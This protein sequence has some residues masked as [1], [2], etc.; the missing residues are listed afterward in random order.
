MIQD[1]KHRAAEAARITDGWQPEWMQD[2]QYKNEPLF[3]V[4]A[5]LNDEAEVEYYETVTLADYINDNYEI[6]SWGGSTSVPLYCDTVRF[7]TGWTMVAQRNR[8]CTFEGEELVF[9]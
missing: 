9:R 1:R 4:Q 6:P 8:L 7:E 3:T 5:I 2:G